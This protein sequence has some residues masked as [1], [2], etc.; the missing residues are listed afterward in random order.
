MLNLRHSTK[1]VCLQAFRDLS[2]VLAAKLASATACRTAQQDW[3]GQLNALYDT[4]ATSE[5]CEAQLQQLQRSSRL[6]TEHV[7]HTQVC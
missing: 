6:L 3:A 1:S 2:G 5:A 4:P 7:Q